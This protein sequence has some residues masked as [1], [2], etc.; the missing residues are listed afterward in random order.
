MVPGSENAQPVAILFPPSEDT[1]SQ[2]ARNVAKLTKSASLQG[3]HAEDPESMRLLKQLSSNEQ[4]QMASRVIITQ[5]SASLQLAVK[6]Y[7]SDK[8][9]ADKTGNAGESS[10]GLSGSNSKADQGSKMNSSSLQKASYSPPQANYTVETTPSTALFPDTGTDT[11]MNG[12]NSYTLTDLF[13]ASAQDL[14]G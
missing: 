6:N 14:S 7:A 8:T 9:A 5:G 12:W 3:F 13:A 2:T 4:M 10:P 1:Q 11:T